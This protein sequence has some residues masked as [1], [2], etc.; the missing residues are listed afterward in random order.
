VNPGRRASAK[1][2]V[3]QLRDVMVNRLQRVLGDSWTVVP[4]RG[5]VDLT[6]R[7]GERVVGLW[8]TERQQVVWFLA[9]STEALRPYAGSALLSLLAID[10]ASAGAREVFALL[11]RDLALVGIPEQDQA[12]LLADA[13]K[14][15]EERSA[16]EVRVV[17]ARNARAA[18]DAAL[19][20]EATEVARLLGGAWQVEASKYGIQLTP[21]NEDEQ[22]VWLVLPHD[23]ATPGGFA[24]VR[25]GFGASAAPF[26]LLGRSAARCVITWS[27]LDGARSRALMNA[28]GLEA[29]SAELSARLRERG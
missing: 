17:E 28:L 25:A 19:R 12:A 1:I 8:T 16:A 5:G 20:A 6:S 3:V 2:G 14:A 9:D 13:A 26:A 27:D 24:A 11:E 10:P 29:P 22:G 7:G 18:A 23:P 15:R 4:R 21:T